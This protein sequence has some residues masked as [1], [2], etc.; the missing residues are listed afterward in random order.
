MAGSPCPAIHNGWRPFHPSACH[1][2]ACHNATPLGSRY[3]LEYPIGQ[4]ASGRV[5]YARRRAD[6]TAVAIKVLR[7]EYAADP[8]LVTRFLRERTTLQR[9]NHP[10]LVKVHDLV[11]EGDTLAVVMEL[12]EG[13]DLRRIAQRGGLDVEG[14]LIVL[15]QVA[16]AVA[17]IH[18]ASI[19][20]RDIK[21]ENIL[22]AE[23][24]GELWS[25]LTDFGLASAADGQLLTRS[26]HMVG[27]PAYLAPELL[28]SRPYGPPIDVYALGVTAYELF[29]GVRPFEGSNPLALMRAQL[30]TEARK[31]PDMADEHWQ[32]VRGCLAKRPKD[33]PTAAALATRLER[34]L[35]RRGRRSAVGTP[36]RTRSPVPGSTGPGLSID[37][38]T[39]TT[40][41]L[42]SWPDGQVE[43]LLIDGS[44]LMPS[45]V[46]VEPSGTIL[47]G[48]EALD[49]ARRQPHRCDPYPKLRIDATARLGDRDVD[50]VDAIAALLRRVAT[51][52]RRVAGA[53]PTWL[54]MTHP[55]FWQ[56]SHAALLDR[57]ARSAGLPIPRLVPEPVAAGMQ[58]S[59]VAGVA[60][61]A[62]AVAVLCDIGAAAVSVSVLRHNPGQG[63]EILATKSEPNAGGIDIDAAILAHVGEIVSAQAPEMWGRLSQPDNPEDRRAAWQLWE[64][65][66]RAKEQLSHA[67]TATVRPPLVDQ[68]VTLDRDRLNELARPILNR[69]VV[70]TL[71]AIAAADVPED[72]IAATFLLG[73]SAQIPIAA[74]FLHRAVGPAPTLIERPELV[75]ALGAL[76]LTAPAP[77]PLP[78]P[79]VPRI[80]HP[81]G[82]GSARHNVPPVRERT[83]LP[84][85]GR[86]NRQV[87]KSS[88]RSALRPRRWRR[89]MATRAGIA[90][91]A[92]L[93]T[94]GT[95][96]AVA[97]GYDPR[98]LIGVGAAAA[99]G[100]ACDYKIA[101]LGELNDF[102]GRAVRN[103]AKLAVEQYN[104]NHRTCTV[105]LVEANT[106]NALDETNGLASNR[107][108]G[109]VDDRRVL[110]VIGP[111][112]GE[113][114]RVAMPIFDRVQLPGITPAAS[115]ND[116]SQDG[117]VAF[118]RIIGS[119]RQD[120]YAGVHHL[121]RDLH[122]TRTFVVDDRSPEARAAV[123]RLG[124]AW[125]GQASVDP[126]GA[127]YSATVAKIK[128]ANPDSLLY[129]GYDGPG[130]LLIKQVRAALPNLLIMTTVR[131]YE[132]PLVN[133]AGNAAENVYLTTPEIIPSAVSHDLVTEY[134][135]RFSEAIPFYV[136]ESY[137]AANVLLAG[138]AAGKSTRADMLAWVNGYDHTG[139]SRHVKFTAD[140]DLASP[141]VWAAQIRG[142]RF[143]PQTVIADD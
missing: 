127:N 59:T 84:A 22:V 126:N 114:C 42:L 131:A 10:H 68:L 118:H 108:R 20:H 101:V 65:V 121:T 64:E 77:T 6:H 119:Y 134:Q 41:A 31:P 69:V 40:R 83:P 94:A 29:S 123:D 99:H 27:T 72:A 136:A 12:V 38:G 1:L 11:V 142:G 132:D 39:A 105:T 143:T 15:A 32:I 107:A 76:A 124:N 137:D 85:S 111:L 128:A 75:V 48:R 129:T 90:A 109:L 46:F 34:L 45:A 8:D 26:S 50:M 100:P 112:T 73:G 67:A 30:D 58:L 79:S 116:L 33:R 104:I 113:D 70:A 18:R 4:G 88:F 21:P 52:A 63:P 61:P 89:G 14:I 23:Y 28:L 120:T 44:P 16:T 82:S 130:A 96:T 92:V 87:P 93:L 86:R 102:V 55:P 110:G 35:S 51:E 97:T 138:L 115:D 24:D 17:Y 9:L 122:A 60:V 2:P 71:S 80:S 81:G 53:D 54:T 37:L 139:V 43:P 117:S 95:A 7:P 140:G 47:T 62:G 49:A 56:P 57:A 125:V 25:R 5:W 78:T 66:Q 36:A 133:G 13:A 3:F 19:L 91:A 103:G 106:F 135:Q 141:Q 74:S 98:R